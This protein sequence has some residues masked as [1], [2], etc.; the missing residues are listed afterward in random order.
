[1]TRCKKRIFWEQVSKVQTFEQASIIR[2][3]V[4]DLQDIE[5]LTRFNGREVIAIGLNA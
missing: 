4:T 5:L 3:M 2:M 1:M